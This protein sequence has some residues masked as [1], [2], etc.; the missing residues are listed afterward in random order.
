MNEITNFGSYLNELLTLRGIDKK[1]FA[2]SMNINRSLLYR[3]LSSEQL[4]DQDQLNEISLKLNLRVSEQR[5]LWE[6]YECTQYG[7]EI[8]KGRKLITDMLGRLNNKIHEKGITYEYTLK[9]WTPVDENAGV[10]PVTNKTNVMN[11]V[12]SLLDS[13]RQNPD[14]STVKIILQPDL[15]D[16]ISI[17]T[18]ILNE[19]T[20]SKRDISIDHIIRFKDTLLKKNRLHNLELLDS[21]LPLSSFENIYGIYYATENLTTEA[22]ETFFPNFISIDS[23]TAFVFSEDYENGILYTSECQETI[24]LMNAEFT[25]IC[26]DCLPLFINLETYEKQS[27]YMYEYERMVQAATSL[28]HP[29]NG[30]Y[31]FPADII[32]KKVKE[33][34]LAKEHAQ[35][36]IK[37]TEIFCERLKKSKA[38]E[39]I[40]LA[41]LRN[42]AVTGQLQIYRNIKFS[43]SER[44][45]VLKHLLKF[46]EEQENYSL[47]LMKEDNPFYDSDFAVY[48]IG[49]QLLYIVPSYTDFKITDNI[50]IRNKGIVESFTDFMHSSFTTNNSIIDR[51]E[52]ASIISN[53]IET[54]QTL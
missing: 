22:Y 5:K 43:K 50:I 27:L 17:L 31:T 21:L 12:L 11:M 36:L 25:K 46:L 47:Y 34:A 9:S 37:R 44:I 3:F 14:I 51:N 18:K 19:I 15:Q 42:F 29:E 10:V 54:T 6:S 7:W 33:H 16:F 40:S 2:A 32:N 30:F 41:G 24:E 53:I 39:I 26:D 8:V 13:V 49:S 4:P 23:K 52:V 45:E 48:T 28:L 35:L 1:H 20:D 38:L